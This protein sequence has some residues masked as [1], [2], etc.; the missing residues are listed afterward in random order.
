MIVHCKLLLAAFEKA[1]KINS[2]FSGGECSSGGENCISIEGACNWFF[3]VLRAK[4]RVE[5]VL[6][7]W[8]FHK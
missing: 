5:C 7:F 1:I 3:H 8:P 4:R 2:L 6:W